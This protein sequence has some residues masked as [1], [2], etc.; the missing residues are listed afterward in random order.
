MADLSVVDVEHSVCTRG[1]CVS[2]RHSGIITS[3]NYPNNYPN[4]FDESHTIEVEE[5][6]QINLEVTDFVLYMADM[7]FNNS[8]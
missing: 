7:S 5:G 1:D 2:N 8:F 6:E 3:P 4:S